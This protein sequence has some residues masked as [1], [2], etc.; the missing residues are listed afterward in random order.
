MSSQPVLDQAEVDALLNGMNSGAVSTEAAPVDG[1]VRQYD[2][3]KEARIVRGRMPTL[4]MMNERFARLYR[5]SL[6]NMLRRSA[7]ISVRGVQ[8]FKFGEYVHRLHVPTS[9]NL[10]K[11]A[12]LRGTA[13]VVLSPRLVFTVVDNFFGGKGRHAKIEGRDFTA[14]ETRIIS[15]LLEAAF[16]DLKEA[17]SNVLPIDIEY[18]ASE[19]NP[20]F[21]NIVS[22]TEI[23]VVATFSIELDGG[24]GELHLTLPYSMIEPMREIFDAGI[25]SDRNDDDGRWRIS[26][27]EELED[28]EV[29]LTTVLGRSCVT[30]EQLLNFKPGD[31]VPCDFDGRAT[32]YAEDI[33]V[34][35]GSFGISR[36]QQAVKI[37]N[38]L[39]RGRPA[40]VARGAHGATRTMN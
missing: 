27:R 3:G 8:T 12:P 34:L 33:P 6:Y 23:V 5:M 39:V 26:L 40:A 29:E 20:Q 30:L 38:T 16:V 21:A 35:R 1:D 22:P 18:V 15:M 32:V 9:L 11:I 7:A 4:E 25:Q 2:L 14:T 36:G 28:A 24:T 10:V 13:L 31:I 19:M 37:E 17:W